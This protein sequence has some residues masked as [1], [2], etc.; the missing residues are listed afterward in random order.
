MRALAA[1]AALALGLAQIPARTEAADFAAGVAAFDA[2]D[3]AEAWLQ[4]WMLAEDGDPAAQY[5][6]GQFYREGIG[7]PAD[8]REA[9]RWYEKAAVQGHALG[10]YALGVMFENGDGGRR[11]LSSARIWY[12]RA[13]EQKVDPAAAALERVE[14]KLREPPR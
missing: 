5:N 9:R 6:L 13:K 10:E 12:G 4:F 8:L 7:I 3:N 1:A 2:G 14:L 11:D